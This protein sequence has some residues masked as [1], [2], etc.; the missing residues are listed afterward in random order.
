M[1]FV[2]SRLKPLP[3]HCC[4]DSYQRVAEE[5]LRESLEAAALERER[6]SEAVTQKAED[7]L[8]QQ[9]IMATLSRE[10]ES[11]RLA[12][13]NARQSLDELAAEKDR[14]T[15]LVGGLLWI[16]ANLSVHV[17]NGVFPVARGSVE[18]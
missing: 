1:V 5:K 4:C 3:L 7:L 10:L 2:F 16:G 11:Q 9:E 18:C 13:A 12:E 17:R 15:K 8:R 14:L 6:L